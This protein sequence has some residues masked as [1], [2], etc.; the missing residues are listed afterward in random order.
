MLILIFV[1]VPHNP[2]DSAGSESKAMYNGL[3][4]A[5]GLRMREDKKGV[6]TAD[7]SVN[8]KLD[9]CAATREVYVTLFYMPA[10]YLIIAAILRNSIQLIMA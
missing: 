8:T 7:K 3:I 9:S 10:S 4:V 6:L 5:F 2:D 1:T